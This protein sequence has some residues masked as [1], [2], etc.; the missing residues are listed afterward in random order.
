MAQGTGS[1]FAALQVLVGDGATPTEVFTAICGVM[2]KDIDYASDVVETEMPD[3]SDESL[4]SF[5]NTGI[6]AISIKVACSGKWTKE[7]HGIMLNWW[8]SAANKNIKLRYVTAATGDV[9]YINGP[10]ICANLKN[11]V[12]KGAYMDGS[13]DIMFASQPTY[14]LKP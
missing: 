11:G 12:S 1:T 3:C 14:V 13:F 7:S 10:A 5:K 8:K 6:K 4:P 2:Q 9:E